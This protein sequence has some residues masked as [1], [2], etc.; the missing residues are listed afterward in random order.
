MALNADI[1]SLDN[2][3][4][5]VTSATK[6]IRASDAY[7]GM[8]TFQVVGMAGATVLTAQGSIDNVPT[9]VTMG[10]VPSNSTTMATTITADGIYRCDISGIQGFRL[11]VSTTGTGT[12]VVTVFTTEG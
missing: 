12:T 7:A 2:T 9:Y 1:F 5:S 8:V 4:N 6:L 11:R 3:T 10:V